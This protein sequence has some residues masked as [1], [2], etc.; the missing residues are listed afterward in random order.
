MIDR[1]IF[2]FFAAAIA[3]ACEPLPYDKP[4]AVELPPFGTVTAKQFV[5]IFSQTCVAHFSDLDNVTASLKRVGF[6]LEPRRSSD[7]GNFRR[8]SHRNKD[9]SA[10]AGFAIT[11]GIGPRVSEASANEFCSVS[12]LL[13][14]PE[15]LIAALNELTA[16]DGVKIDFSDDSKYV[17]PAFRTGSFTNSKGAPVM[18]TFDQRRTSFPPRMDIEWPE[19]CDVTA[20]CVGWNYAKLEL[21]WIPR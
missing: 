16:P 19:V 14:N 15:M 18:L 11:S 8:F 1:R 17:D 5:S 3:S 9:L 21:S 12:A 13:A 10:Y 6:D 20:K 2:W 7:H 4:P